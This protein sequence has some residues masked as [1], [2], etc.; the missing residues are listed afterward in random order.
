MPRD[1][2]AEWLAKR[3]AEKAA[4]RATPGHGAVRQAQIKVDQILEQ[5]RKTT[6][7][8]TGVKTGKTEKSSTPVRQEEGRDAMAEWLAARKESKVQQIAEQGKYAVRNVGS[9]YKAATGMWGEL[10]K[11]NEW[12]GLGVDAGI[13]QGYQHACR[14]GAGASCSSRRRTLCR[15]TRQGRTARG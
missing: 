15:W 4:Q 6:T 14:C 2:M 10:R 8:L 9:L 11:A 12:Q 5:A 13:R 3:N 1:A 7:A